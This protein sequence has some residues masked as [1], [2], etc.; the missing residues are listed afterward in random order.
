MNRVNP[1]LAVIVPC[2]N[3]EKILHESHKVFYSILK[4]MI[5]KKIISSKSYIC[6]VN[7]GSK[8]STWEIIK[9]FIKEDEGV[10][11]ISLA[12][13]FGLQGALAAGLYTCKADAYI[14]IDCDLQEDP[15]VIYQLTKE[16]K[17]GND[18]VYAVRKSR[19]GDGWFRTFAGNLFYKIM[20]LLGSETIKNQSEVRLI[21]S[22]IVEVLKN[23]NEKNLYLRGMIPAVG[24][25]STKVYYDRKARIG[26]TSKWSFIKLFDT[27]I[28]GM[29]TTTTKLL[30]YILW[31]GIFLAL[32]FILFFAGFIIASIVNKSI[33]W[34]LLIISILNFIGAIIT[35]SLGI[36]GAYIGKV[37]K[38]VRNRPPFTIGEN[39]TD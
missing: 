19:T 11:G 32:I 5:E 17:N 14:T 13:N 38:E 36:I 23:T 2:Y 24:Y 1:V 35:I 27:A 18:T 37:Y 30:T 22:R 34:Y 9:S 25:P 39:L 16:Y 21:S 8:D 7:D 3:E 10:K 12:R 6:Y 33:H 26:G 31:S 20:D 29:T 4:D 15:E 28:D